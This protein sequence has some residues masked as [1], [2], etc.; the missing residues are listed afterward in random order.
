MAQGYQRPG[1]HSRQASRIS[2]RSHT[3]PTGNQEPKDV[4]RYSHGSIDQATVAF[5]KQTL[6]FRPGDRGIAE[7]ENSNEVDSQNLGELLPPLTSSNEVDLQL[8]ALLAVILNQFVQAWYNKITADQ[9]FVREII[10]IVAHCTRGLEQRV[11]NSDL[12]TL[13][14][15]ELPD[16]V[17]MHVEGMTCFSGIR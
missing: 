12:E 9:D 1:K 7:N 13:L 8:Y 4:D 2:N 15:D 17:T 6:C 10:Q 3:S 11:R 14:L 5:I 16:L